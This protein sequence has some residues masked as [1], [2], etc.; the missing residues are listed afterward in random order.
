MMKVASIVGARPQFVKAAMVSRA[1]RAVGQEV[2][3]HT[4]QHYDANMSRVFF[5][6][7]NIPQPDMHLG[8]G[9][10]THAEQ[11]GKMMIEIEKVLLQ[12]RPDFTLVYGD[13]NSTLAGALSAVKLNIPVAHV[14]AGLRS[15]NRSMPEEINRVLCDSISSFLFCPTHVSVDNLAREGVTSGVYQVGDVMGDALD[16]YIAQAQA[17]STILVDH[18]LLPKGYALV[19]VHRAVNTDDQQRLERILVALGRLGMPVVFPMH[20]R[21]QKAI[22]Q[23]HMAVPIS[24]QVID[25][26][27]YLDMLQLEANADCILTDSGGVQKEAYWLG[28]RCV[29]LREETEWVETV[30]S[31]W[32]CLV[33]SDADALVEAVTSWWPTEQRQPFYGDG[34]AA[35]KISQIL[36]AS[37]G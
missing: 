35:E 2:L 27:G 25:P 37:L 8:I 15:Y 19:T 13:T 1:I 33:G 4:G 14:E 32:N 30:E 11:T 10:G 36:T 5:D 29:T 18:H 28:V 3:V 16:Y 7:L 26:V 21:T 20:P 9:S 17:R 31:G 22:E 24:V 23:Y 6:E 12:E 34:H